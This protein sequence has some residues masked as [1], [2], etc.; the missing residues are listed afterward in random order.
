MYASKRESSF[1]TLVRIPLNRKTGTTFSQQ[2]KLDISL[3]NLKEKNEFT[4]K[5]FRNWMSAKL[6]GKLRSAFR[7]SMCVQSAK[8]W[9]CFSFSRL[10]LLLQK[11]TSAL[12]LLNILQCKSCKRRGWWWGERVNISLLPPESQPHPAKTNTRP[13]EHTSAILHVLHDYLYHLTSTALHKYLYLLHSISI[14][15]YYAC[16][17]P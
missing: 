14:I 6:N 5:R 12:H 1:E 11:N 9:G 2:K 4:R 3:R 17:A 13:V 16:T 15:S 10:S 7:R 8:A